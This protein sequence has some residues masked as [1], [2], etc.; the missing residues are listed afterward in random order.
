MNSIRLLGILG[1]WLA[2]SAEVYAEHP[3]IRREWKVDGVVRKTLVYTLPK[4]KSDVA[5]VIFAVH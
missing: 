5:T 2:A 4:A 3:L 1:L